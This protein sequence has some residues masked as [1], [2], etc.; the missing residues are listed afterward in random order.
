MH[1]RHM[2]VGM[3]VGPVPVHMAVFAGRHCVVGVVVM[4]VIVAVGMLVFQRLMLMLV[5]V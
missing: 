1:V 3:L 5:A 2:R 4:P